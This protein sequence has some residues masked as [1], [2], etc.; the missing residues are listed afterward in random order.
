M[1]GS[2]AACN[3]ISNFGSYFPIIS[4][5]IGIWSLMREL[6]FSY[7]DKYI[8]LF[9]KYHWEG[10]VHNAGEWTVGNELGIKGAREGIIILYFFDFFLLLFFV[11]LNLSKRSIFFSLLLIFSYFFLSF[12]IRY[13]VIKILLSVY[14]VTCRV[15]AIWRIRGMRN[16]AHYLVH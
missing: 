15:N 8:F 4:H 5:F 7:R 1:A 14:L 6:T 11:I 9:V 10:K 16:S 12:S 2:S 13:G 3:W